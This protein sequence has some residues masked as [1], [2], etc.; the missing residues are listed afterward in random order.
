ML[1]H[2]GD[3]AGLQADEPTQQLVEKAPID[4][5]KRARILDYSVER[6]GGRLVYTAQT[7]QRLI[8]AYLEHTCSLAAAAHAISVSYRTACTWR[9]EHDDLR[10]ALEECDALFV[11]AV[12]QMFKQRVM[13]PRERNPAWMIFFLKHRSED[14]R[15]RTKAMTT[16]IEMSDS[17]VRRASEAVTPPAPAPAG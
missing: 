6:R 9:L 2:E 8:D 3:V 16:K 15:E 5:A 10:E 12:E 11:Q 17:S 4:T 14:F 13:D 1:E 7:K